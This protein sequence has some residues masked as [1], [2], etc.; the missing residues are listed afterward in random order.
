MKEEKFILFN[1]KQIENPSLDLNLNLNLE[2]KSQTEKNMEDKKPFE[3]FFDNYTFKFKEISDDIIK[4][5]FI[6]NE[7]KKNFL[8]KFLELN[9]HLLNTNP[10]NLI[11]E[12]EVK[13]KLKIKQKRKEKK[14]KE[15]LFNLI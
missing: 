12:Y 8:R 5:E 6:D 1:K 4:N 3:S 15:Y 9:N 10:E 14:R 2:K 7:F 13:I 11:K